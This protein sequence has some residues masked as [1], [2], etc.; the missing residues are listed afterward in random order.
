MTLLV[1]SFVRASDADRVGIPGLVVVRA[2]GVAAIAT[3][4]DAPPT[5]TEDALRAH[6]AMTGAIHDA[7]PSL[8]A[9]F[10]SIFAGRDEL[11]QALA[12]REAALLG[13][14]DAV[15]DRIEM[16]VTLSWR[17]ARAGGTADA[18]S[19]RAYM[20]A[21]GTRER[22]RE[23]AEQI[24]ARLVGELGYERAFTRESICPRGGVAATVALLIPRDEVMRVRRHVA[25]FRDRTSEVMVAAYGPLAP[26]SF[27]S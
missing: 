26:Y 19:G 11:A 16:S 6:V 21:L 25:S 9:R 14:L 15:G 20:E 2:G 27:A 22:E 10:G 13:A 3:E 4:T 12:S 24:T 18:S 8:P 5:A 23:R 1:R 17:T 7:A